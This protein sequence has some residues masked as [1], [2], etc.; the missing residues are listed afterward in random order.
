MEKINLARL[1]KGEYV[2]EVVINPDEA[3]AFKEGKGDI[4]DALKSEQVF[5]DAKKGNLASEKLMH[6]V[7]QT[8]DP[9]EVASIII[10]KGEIQDTSEHRNK[11]REEKEKQIIEMIHR[12]AIDPTTKLP[13]P[14]Q[15]IQNA[16][17][18]AKVHID[19][20]KSVE[21]QLPGIVKALQPIIPIKMEIV[22]LQLHIPA[23]YAAKCY[24]IIKNNATIKKESWQP[25]GSWLG[26]ISMPAGIRHDLID[27]LNK[28]THGDM[29]SKQ[30]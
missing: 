2:F 4:R 10:K 27:K 13:H 22:E 16:M 18:E 19:D 29:E 12:N 17:A 20:H 25:D 28:I 23:H 30:V 6:E 26:T 14:P 24:G 5:H 11:E 8:D 9:L 3:V 15:R 1:K 21:E 7:F